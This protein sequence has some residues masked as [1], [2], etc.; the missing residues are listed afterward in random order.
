MRRD[1]RKEDN[2]FCKASANKIDKKYFQ[3][4]ETLFNL[5]YKYPSNH[6]AIN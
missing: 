3:K 5:K 1:L 2:N 6:Q 4:K